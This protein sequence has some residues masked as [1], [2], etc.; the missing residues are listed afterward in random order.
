MT[1]A[2]DERMNIDDFDDENDLIEW[3]LTAPDDAVGPACSKVPVPPTIANDDQFR[4]IYTQAYRH[5]LAAV[6]LWRDQRESEL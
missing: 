3:A 5:A 1:V 4:E 2:D 6:R